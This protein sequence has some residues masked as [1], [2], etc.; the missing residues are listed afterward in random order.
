M[1]WVNAFAHNHLRNSSRMPVDSAAFPSHEQ[2]YSQP[3]IQVSTNPA[4]QGYLF[5]EPTSTSSGI[6]RE[7]RTMYNQSLCFSHL[8]DRPSSDEPLDMPDITHYISSGFDRDLSEALSALYKAHCTS[9]VDAVRYVKEK[10]FIKLIGSFNGT[11]TVP[12]AKLFQ[13]SSIA[14]WIRECDRVMYQQIIKFVSQLVLQV[15]PQPV[16]LMLRTIS[17]D[18]TEHITKHFRQYPDHVLQSKLEM[19]TIF[20]SLLQ[21]LLRV[22]ET[23]HAAANLLMKD[24]MRCI[25]WQDWVNSVKPKRV[26]E[27][28]L[29]RCGHEEAHAVLTADMR[30]L[31]AP[32]PAPEALDEPPEYRA[33]AAQLDIEDLDWSLYATADTIM[34]RWSAFLKRLP[35]RFPDVPTRNLLHCIESVGNAALRDVTVSVAQSFGAWWTTK[36][37]IDE[38]MLWLAEMG[39]FLDSRTPEPSPTHAHSFQDYDSTFADDL[40][41]ST[42]ADE[43][44]RPGTATE[45]PRPSS[46]HPALDFG[47]LHSFS[48]QMNG[49][50]HSSGPPT[51][52]CKFLHLYGNVSDVRAGGTLMA[53]AE[54]FA[55]KYHATPR[56][57]KHVNGA[58]DSFEDS[59]IGLSLL[60]EGPGGF[61]GFS[62]WKPGTVPPTGFTPVKGGV[63]G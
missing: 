52:T 21:R 10:Q 34:E 7:T 42:R 31:L 30:L 24:N 57:D 12:V 17:M 3:Q 36:V 46:A 4:S 37:W 23:A 50:R 39:G 27:S 26:V 33:A 19:A 9:L 53:N 22:N 38:Y 28:A 62:P 45:L 55:V 16:Y 54:G 47:G 58:S 63:G 18:L 41:H 2:I 8:N 44:S 20:S 56:A 60:A 15:L 6:G 14:P 35:S 11:M 49:Q 29:S 1:D 59:G 61:V 13:Q 48:P 5:A 25:M 40:R 43:I 51:A 32:L